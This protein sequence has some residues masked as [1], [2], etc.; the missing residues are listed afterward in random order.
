MLFSILS[1]VSSPKKTREPD[2]R[3][4]PV[5]KIRTRSVGRKK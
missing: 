4:I 3:G 1:M 5:R 2:A